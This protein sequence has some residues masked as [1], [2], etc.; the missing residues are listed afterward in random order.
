MVWR[1]TRDA[2]ISPAPAGGQPGYGIALDWHWRYGSYEQPRPRVK[3]WRVWR[4]WAGAGSD[5]L[6]EFPTFAQAA[7]VC[8]L[9]AIQRQGLWTTY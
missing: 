6:G 1:A 7:Q 2:F 8:E 9:D 5:R 4:F 3:V